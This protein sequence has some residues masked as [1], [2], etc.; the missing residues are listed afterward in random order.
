M[1][2]SQN[3]HKNKYFILWTG[4]ALHNSFCWL[5]KIFGDKNINSFGENLLNLVMNNLIWWWKNDLCWWEWGW[6]ARN[7]IARQSIGRYFWQEINCSTQNLS[8]ARIQLIL[9][10]LD[11]SS[12]QKK[13]P[14]VHTVEQLTLLSSATYKHLTAKHVHLT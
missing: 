4:F 7:S 6:T 14:M 8:N 10:Q 12:W 11:S 5:V 3:C 2:W 13:W 1:F 9:A